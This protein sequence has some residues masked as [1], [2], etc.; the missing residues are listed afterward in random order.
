MSSRFFNPYVGSKYEEG[1]CKK[2]ILVV[3]AS[4]YCNK[5]GEK[6]RKLCPFFNE[7]TSPVIKDSSKFDTICP[8]YIGQDLKLS[9][10]PSNAIEARYRAYQNFASFMRQYKKKKNEDVWD[11]MAFT[12]Y[13][14]FFSP[15][16]DT[17]KEYFSKRDFS[18]FYETLIELKPN[19]VVVWGLAVTEEIRDNKENNGYI[20][21]YDKLPETDYYVCHMQLPKVPHE[22][23][24][25][26]CF[27][28]SSVKYWYG[29]LEVL[30]KH[31]SNVLKS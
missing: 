26:C 5:D 10:E 3:G 21:D 13:L 19:I 15:T 25:V 6:G 16:I 29:D 11:R 28:P 4:F 17:K 8:E 12:D 23:S 2:R 14:Q 22:I 20:T 1:I 27:H 9:E 18:A 24:L 7:C 31:M 30:T